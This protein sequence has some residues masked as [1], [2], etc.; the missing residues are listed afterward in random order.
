MQCLAAVGL[1]WVVYVILHFGVGRQCRHGPFV[2]YW[3][4]GLVCSVHQ[5]DMTFTCFVFG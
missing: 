2:Q 1:W 4:W 3:V 5:Y